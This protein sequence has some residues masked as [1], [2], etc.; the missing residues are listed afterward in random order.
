MEI[1]FKISSGLFHLVFKISSGLF[2]LDT[3]D[4]ARRLNLFFLLLAGNLWFILEIR[5]SLYSLSKRH[6]L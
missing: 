5:K 1:V 6:R 2:H 3:A 4:Q